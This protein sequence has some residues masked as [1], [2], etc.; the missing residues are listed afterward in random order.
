[1]NLTLTDLRALSLASALIGRDGEVVA[2]TPEWR[3]DGPGA[4][5]YPV[6]KNRLVVCVEPAAPE[7]A[8]LLER[9]LGE[10]DTAAAAATRQRSLQVRML[11]ASLRLVAGRIVPG[12]DA[13]TSDEVLQLARAGIEART[14]LRIL[15]ASGSS[16]TVSGGEAAALAVVQLAVNAERHD[17]ADSVTVAAIRGGFA[18]VW[19]GEPAARV[20]S[21]RPRSDRN[22]WGLG[23]A[24][25]AADAIGGTVH[26]PH[27]HDSNEQRALVE[28]GS[29]RLTLPLAAVRDQRVVRATRSWDEETGALPGTPVTANQHIL[30]A[31]ARAA[32]QPGTIVRAGSL[33]A[34]RSADQ[35]WIAVPPDDAADR[36]RDVVDGLTHE[37]ALVDGV[38]EPQRSRI[39]AV[40]Q[41]L[42]HA[43]GAPLQRVVASAWTRR[44]QALAVPFALPMPVPAVTGA[45]A[46]DPTVTALIAAEAGDTFE[47][48]GESLWLRLRPGGT[49]NEL[50]RA[51]VSPGSDRILLS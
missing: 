38:A 45:A 28:V 11:A 17:G 2:C 7:C 41:L 39:N 6:R 3:G 29:P 36:A 19:Q 37:Q 34:R 47:V 13:L 24:R 14:G 48:D 33:A 21:A 51:L 9:L 1:M 32:R 42:N 31:C 4:A 50:V 18:V 27:R 49:E 8:A 10:L 26:P 20:A 35:T 5:S 46:L 15:T 22:R 23:F 40:A 12:G 44:M 25:I 43:L 16:Y 30:D